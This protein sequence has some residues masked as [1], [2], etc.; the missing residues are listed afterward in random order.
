MK[1]TRWAID[2]LFGRNHFED[3]RTRSTTFFVRWWLI[4]ILTAILPVARFGPLVWRQWRSEHAEGLCPNCGYDLRATPERCPEC[5]AEVSDQ[6]SAI[7]N[8]KTANPLTSHL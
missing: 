5:G 6:K 2:S 1:Q 4:V 8:G 3:G 7:S